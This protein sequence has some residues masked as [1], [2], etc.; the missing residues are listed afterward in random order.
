MKQENTFRLKFMNEDGS[1]NVD[2][3]L[4]TVD[5]YDARNYE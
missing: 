5:S 3:V 1:L 2:A 4:A